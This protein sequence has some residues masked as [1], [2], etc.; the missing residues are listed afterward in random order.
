[1]AGPAPEPPSSNGSAPRGSTTSCTV[2][3]PRWGF[4]YLVLRRPDDSAA[5]ALPRFRRAERSEAPLEGVSGIGE[6]LAQALRARDAV[7]RLDD[8]ALRRQRLRVA[9]DV[10]EERSHWP[11]AEEPS[12]IVLR[13]GGGLRRELRVDPA[14]AAVVGACDGELPLGVIS[15][16]VAELLGVDAAALAPAVLTEVRELVIDGVLTPVL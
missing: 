12:V 8:D 9:G 16:A 6:H 14:L 15:D 1:M 13:Q 3:S 7:A 4:G 2:A 5:D 10:T 11:G